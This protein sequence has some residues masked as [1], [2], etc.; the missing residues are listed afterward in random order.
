M[1][2]SRLI[3]IIVKEV[4]NEL[5]H[6][7]YVKYNDKYVSKVE[8]YDPYNYFYITEDLIIYNNTHAKFNNDNFIEKL[9]NVLEDYA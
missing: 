1:Q 8:I 7:S 3:K 4:L 5:C 9:K 2:D 6:V